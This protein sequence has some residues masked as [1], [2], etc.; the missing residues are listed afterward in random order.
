MADKTL[1][2][3]GRGWKEHDG[4]DKKGDPRVTVSCVILADAELFCCWT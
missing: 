1:R 4:L 3:C 2:L